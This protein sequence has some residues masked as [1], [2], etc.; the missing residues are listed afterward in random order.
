MNTLT[1]MIECGGKPDLS[2]ED[3]MA[4]IPIEI[5][6]TNGVA[7]VLQTTLVAMSTKAHP[8]FPNPN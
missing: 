4:W 5:L 3:V 7:R 2:K 8:P 1:Q 6:A